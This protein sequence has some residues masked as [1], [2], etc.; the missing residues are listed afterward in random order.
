ME[1][2][3]NF[4]AITRYTGPILCIVYPFI[5]HAPPLVFKEKR[6][7]NGNVSQNSGNR[8]H[9]KRQGL[10]N[11]TS[12]CRGKSGC[13]Q[14]ESFLLTERCDIMGVPTNAK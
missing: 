2:S 13:P 10:P 14:L 6:L 1:N 8:F 5:G 4:G 7:Q 3:E 9:C 12:L 11:E